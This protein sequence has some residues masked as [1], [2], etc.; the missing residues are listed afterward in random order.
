MT[1]THRRDIERFDRW[2]ANYDRSWTQ[3]IF[4]GPVHR[5]AV[6]VAAG[7]AP[8]PTRILDVGCGTGALLRV[9][10]PR[11]SQADLMGADAS[12]EM[13]RAADVAN[14]LPDRIHFA[15]AQAEELPFP[16]G[17]FELVLSTISFHH[18]G[19]Q[20]KGLREVERVLA[21]GGSFLLADHF[22][23]PLQRVFFA[24][25]GRRKRFH[26]R[27]EI[28]TMLREAGLD[29]RGWHDIYKI[30]PLLLVAG[31]TASKARAG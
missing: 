5:G 6:D 24:T 23:L 2:A 21:P 28:D 29:P 18:W 26:T 13:I 25:P 15:W 7:L 20:G 1:S 19:D 8:N 14:P 4:F 11:F 9:V 17:H 16:D 10:A 12:V 3:R 22:A 30:G 31:V 27:A